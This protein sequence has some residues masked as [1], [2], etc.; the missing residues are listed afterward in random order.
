MKQAGLGRRFLALMLDWA[1]SS[2]VSGFIFAGSLGHG[3]FARLGIFFIEVW[4]LTALTQAS[5]GQ[6]IMKL[7]VVDF[8]SGEL[9]APLKVLL[10]TLLICL[11]IPA[12]FSKDGRGLH[13]HL[14]NSIV[15][16]V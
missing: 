2:I 15:I 6:R 13:D 12:V 9:V 5:A 11:V 8:Q 3:Q 4:I 10:R 1:M 14:A 7:K 16:K